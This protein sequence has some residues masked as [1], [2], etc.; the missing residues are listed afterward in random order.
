MLV[1][2]RPDVIGQLVC[3]DQIA[4]FVVVFPHINFPDM[5]MRGYDY[6]L[7]F[8]YKHSSNIRYCKTADGYIEKVVTGLSN[9]LTPW[10]IPDNRFRY[11]I[12]WIVQRLGKTYNGVPI[13][14][15]DW[16]I[17]HQ[18]INFLTYLRDDFSW[19]VFIFN[20]F[21]RIEIVISGRMNSAPFTPLCIF[22][23]SC[24]LI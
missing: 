17:P 6:W 23:I 20:K 15:N 16:L 13:Y 9:C 4:H 10:Y 8:Y 1:Y 14:H 19:K 24:S 21:C 18:I 22:A 7:W 5:V 11:I 12:Q 3:P 2:H